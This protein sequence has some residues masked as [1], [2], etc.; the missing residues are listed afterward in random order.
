MW[1]AKIKFS[2]KGT[3]IG[4]KAIKYKVNIFGF[5]LSYYYENNWIIVHITGTIVGKPKNIK[6]FASELK[7]E[8]RVKNF[9]LNG[10]FF[11]GTI[12]EPAYAKALYNKD[13]IHLT[14]ALISSQGYEIVNIACFDKS[15]LITA[16][17]IL[18]KKLSG[19]LLSLK[20]KKIT[21][22]SI[23]K[24]HPDLTDKQKEAINLAIK[25]KY[26][27]VPR[28]T[29][30]EKLAKLSKLSFSTFQVHLRKAEAK[31]IP[32]FFE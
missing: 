23:T 6:K 19:E 22:I 8:K 21:T 27:D 12:K 14:P 30:V 17:N 26:Y 3:L 16:I 10:D 29:S 9:E 18:E 24:M 15:P 13:I 25:N 32:Y 2:E 4:S 11:I 20:Q 1:V 28:K 31:L 5:P 7:K